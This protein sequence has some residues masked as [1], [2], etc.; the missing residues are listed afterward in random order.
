MRV[1]AKGQTVS[2]AYQKCLRVA[3]KCFNFFIFIAFCRYRYVFSSGKLTR[4]E[5]KERKKKKNLNCQNGTNCHF[6]CIFF[7]FYGKNANARERELILIV[8]LGCLC[9]VLTRI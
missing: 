2:S 3:F 6:L 9:Q 1:C 8:F 5:K 4:E 7:G